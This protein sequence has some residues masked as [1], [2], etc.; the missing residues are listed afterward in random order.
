MIQPT[1]AQPPAELKELAG[2]LM[3]AAKAISGKLEGAKVSTE[4]ID[5]SAA[6]TNVVGCYQNIAWILSPPAEIGR[7]NRSP[8]PAETT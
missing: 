6:L 8:N 2:M 1:N 7:L 3:K 5:L 4:I